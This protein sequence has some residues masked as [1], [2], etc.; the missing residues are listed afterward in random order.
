LTDKPKKERALRDYHVLILQRSEDG[1]SQPVWKQ[2]GVE[3]SHDPDEAR[4]AK[5]RENGIPSG[6][7]V[8]VP[9]RSWNPERFGQKQEAPRYVKESVAV[10]SARPVATGTP[11][12][13]PPAGATAA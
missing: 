7:L 3:R 11:V 12:T 5:L 6:T 4:I 2:L 13:S 1:S 9:A 10:E 8:A